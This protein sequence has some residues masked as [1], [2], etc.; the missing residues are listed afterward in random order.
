MA[1]DPNQEPHLYYLDATLFAQNKHQARGFL[2]A[3]DEN[4]LVTLSQLTAVA[5]SVSQEVS[6]RTLALTELQEYLES[7]FQTGLTE[8]QVRNIAN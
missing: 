8:Q 6:D 7:L 5:G 2:P 4:D 1:I 3:T